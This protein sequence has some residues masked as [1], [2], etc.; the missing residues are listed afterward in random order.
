M[1]LSSPGAC[2]RRRE[3]LLVDVAVAEHDPQRA[4][5]S[6]CEGDEGLLVGLAFGSFAFIERS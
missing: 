3:R 5:P 6:P 2:Q 4:D 1:L